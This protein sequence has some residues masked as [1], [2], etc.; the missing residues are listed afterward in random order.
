MTGSDSE[1]TDPEDVKMIALA[2]SALARRPEA[3][4]AGCVRDTDGRTYVGTTVDLKHLPMSGLRVALAMAVSSGAEGLEAVVVLGDHDPTAEEESAV[5][6][7][8]A[9]HRRPNGSAVR[10]WLCDAHGA[11]RRPADSDSPHPLES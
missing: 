11:I 3:S 10:I 8:G 9:R 1:P 6:E 5:S 4:D 2:R 7:V